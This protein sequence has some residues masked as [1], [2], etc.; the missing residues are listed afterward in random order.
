M[1][2]VLKQEVKNVG[3]AGDIKNVSD[4]YAMNYLFPQEL[5]EAATSAVL[6]RMEREREMK[7]AEAERS[8][9]QAAEA[10]GRLA[11][12]RIVMK[13]ETK[14]RKLFG[15]IRATDIAEA[16]ETSGI[17]GVAAEHIKLTK[18]IK[19]TGE[20]P[21]QAEFGGVQAKFLVA[22]EATE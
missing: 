15:S 16:I 18:A 5:A 10:V 2:V 21:V 8:E 3:R 7:R 1:K 12:S 17:S 11:G 19:E 22:V 4:G 13:R 20:Y 9:K 14:G 6:A